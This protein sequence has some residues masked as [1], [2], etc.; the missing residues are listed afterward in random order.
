[1]GFSSIM[2]ARLT[3]KCIRT[4]VEARIKAPL[5]Y[6]SNR[7]SRLTI[8]LVNSINARA[9]SLPRPQAAISTRNRSSRVAITIRRTTRRVAE[10]ARFLSLSLRFMETRLCVVSRLRFSFF[11]SSPLFLLSSPS[12]LPFPF[13]TVRHDRLKRGYFT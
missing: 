9:E 5:K 11:F 12:S 1:M 10:T 6:A 8:F 13:V 3:G 4:E 7:I 2:T